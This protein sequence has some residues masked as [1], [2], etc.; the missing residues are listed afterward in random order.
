MNC[1]SS[2]QGIRG[3]IK[4]DIFENESIGKTKVSVHKLS[5]IQERKMNEEYPR[6]TNENIRECCY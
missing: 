5:K 1:S 3:Q 6:I 4:A 2:A